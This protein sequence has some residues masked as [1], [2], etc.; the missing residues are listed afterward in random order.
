MPEGT[1][2]KE[3]KG[4]TKG[5]QGSKDLLNNHKETIEE[6]QD[7]V[8]ELLEPPEGEGDLTDFIGVR[9]AE[10]AV[11]EIRALYKGD[12]LTDAGE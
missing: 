4:C 12:S 7:K 3:V 6:L 9:D 5:A 2:F 1:Q 11:F 8:K 10:F